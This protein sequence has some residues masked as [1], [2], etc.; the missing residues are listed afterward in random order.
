VIS[1]HLVYLRGVE[2]IYFEFKELLF[3]LATTRLPRDLV[4][5]KRSGKVRPVLTRFLDDHFLKRLGA[6]IRHT[7][8]QPATSQ[9]AAS[10]KWPESEKDKLIRLKVEERLRIE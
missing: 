1:E 8:S 6:L 7:K 2:I 9:A 3:D 10:R 5:P 4:D